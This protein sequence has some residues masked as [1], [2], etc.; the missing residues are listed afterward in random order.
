MGTPYYLSPELCEEKPYN[1][2]SDIWSLGCIL[3]ELCT[4]RH[5]FEAT[6][7]GALILKIVKGK[8][9]PIS[10][11]YTMALKELTEKLL[12]KDP[13]KR[14]GLSHIFKMEAMK[15]RMHLY[16]YSYEHHQ[17]IINDQINGKSIGS[18]GSKTN[19][20]ISYR[21]MEEI[22]SMASKFEKKVF[23]NQKS[24]NSEIET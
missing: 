5:P 19:S 11:T 14:P 4:Y 24:L 20:A 13:N 12:T 7:Q 17:T 22:K 15:E 2:K 6:N 23:R 18:S 10:S 9:E 21:P 8:F 16:G 3:Y 1:F